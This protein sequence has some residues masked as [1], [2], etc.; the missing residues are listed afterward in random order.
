MFL[1]TRVWKPFLSGV[2]IQLIFSRWLRV[3]NIFEK[4]IIVF[5]FILST[6]TLWQG[7]GT[8]FFFKW[9]YRGQALG[10]WAQ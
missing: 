2:S 7:A 9:Q 4:D 5:I 8:S 6:L 1:L 10:S 3:G